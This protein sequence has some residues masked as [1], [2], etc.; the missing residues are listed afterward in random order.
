[1]NQQFAFIFGLTV[2]ACIACKEDNPESPVP[3]ADSTLANP[4]F[5][6]STLIE[7]GV[8][9]FGDTVAETPTFT[10]RVTG[11]RYVYL[12]VFSNNFVVSNGNIININDNV[13]AWHSGLGTGREGN[14]SYSDGVNVVRGELQIGPPT[15][16]RSGQGYVWAVWAW[17]NNGTEIT[18]SSKEM[19]FVVR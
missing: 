13:W 19:F 8:P 4:V 9:R 15:S 11:R 14:V 3:S 7:V 16:L 18:H 2:L 1:M 10:W 12:G 6:N 17:G 5:P